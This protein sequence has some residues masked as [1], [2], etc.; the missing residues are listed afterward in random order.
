MNEADY[1]AGVQEL[2]Q[3]RADLSYLPQNQRRER[4][5]RSLL[6]QARSVRQSIERSLGLPSS[7][8]EG[9]LLG[10]SDGLSASSTHLDVFVA[11]GRW[12]IRAREHAP[13]VFERNFVPEPPVENPFGFTK[14]R[15][16]A[17]TA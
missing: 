7:E 2:L 12:L 3:F 10:G 4:V 11:V 8:Y 15:A 13:E 14:P 5:S 1:I 9:G 16:P 6:G 17:P